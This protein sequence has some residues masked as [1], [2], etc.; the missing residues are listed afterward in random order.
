VAIF[1]GALH[2]FDLAIGPGMI[3]LGE[4][5]RNPVCLADHVEA[6]RPGVDGV[7]VPWLLCELDAIVGEDRMDLV[8]HDLEHML[9]EFPSCLPVCLIDELGHGELARAV[10]A[11][12]QV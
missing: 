12:E 9:K 6:H 11:Y 1:D 2:P 5:V 8:G 3:G 10:D 7:P 4:A